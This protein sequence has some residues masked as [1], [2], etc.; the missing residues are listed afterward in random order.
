MAQSIKRIFSGVYMRRNFHLCVFLIMA[1]IFLG[2]NSA[3][4][5][6]SFKSGNELFANCQAPDIGNIR[7][8]DYESDGICIGYIMG[9]A[10]SIS[11]REIYTA[12]V[13]GAPGGIAVQSRA[14]FR[15]S[16]TVG[17]IRDVVIKWMQNHPQL[18]DVSADT[19]VGLALSQAFPC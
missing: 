9:V 10:D 17:Q 6:A 1:L 3:P 2:V 7:M 8:P 5:I 12:K 11:G 15:E 19:L 16:V 13:E 4:A 18:R 14:C